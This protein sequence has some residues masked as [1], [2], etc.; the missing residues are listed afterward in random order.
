MER[1]KVKSEEVDDRMVLEVTL[2]IEREVLNDHWAR[3][4]N[5]MAHAAAYVGVEGVKVV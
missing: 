5:G 4:Q 3:N 2:V 1:K